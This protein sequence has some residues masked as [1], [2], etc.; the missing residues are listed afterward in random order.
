MHIWGADI[1]GYVASFD[2]GA[3]DAPEPGNSGGLG[4]RL[5]PRTGK[6]GHGIPASEDQKAQ[7]YYGDQIVASSHPVLQKINPY[8]V[9]LT[10]AFSRGQK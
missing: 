10:L 2:G 5:E 9:E 8:V 6:N 3:L 4:L 7:V 1:G